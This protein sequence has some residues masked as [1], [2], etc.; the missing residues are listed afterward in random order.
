[1][2]R[3]NDQNFEIVLLGN[4]SARE[5]FSALLLEA[6]H[7]VFTNRFPPQNICDLR[8]F[9]GER[10]R[11]SQTTENLRNLIG[12]GFTACIYNPQTSTL[13]V[14]GALVRFSRARGRVTAQE[15]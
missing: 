3:G 12:A 4:N 11:L 2:G 1:L 13:Q 14:C 8:A 7:A 6:I 10:G 5:P 9:R 15:Y